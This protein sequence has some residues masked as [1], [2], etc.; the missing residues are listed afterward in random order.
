MAFRLSSGDVAGFK[1]LF[2]LAILYG[3]MSIIAYSVIHM[4]FITPLGL[5]APLDRFS[6]SRAV[7]HVRVLSKEIDGRQVGRQGLR[8]AA[9][10]IKTQLEKMKEQAGPNLRIEIEENIING[11]F[12]ML[13][14]GHSLSLAYRNHTNIVMRYPIWV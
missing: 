8:E 4:K 2:C 14:L 12:T 1:V 13:F 3:L 10:Y 5:D 7:E 6:E 9:E 11:S